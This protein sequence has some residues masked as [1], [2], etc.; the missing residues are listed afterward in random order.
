MHEKYMKIALEEANMALRA[1]DFPVGCV[2]TDSRGV[3][4]AGRRKNSVVNGNEL[5]HA[6]IVALRRL[7]RHHQHRVAPDLVVYSTMEPCLMC[8]SALIL[9]NI[10]TIVYAYEDVM[11]GGTK[12]PLDKLTPLY[13]SMK[14]NVIADVLR[15]ES[16]VLFKEFFKDPANFYWQDSLLARYTSDLPLTT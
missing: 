14:I 11:G 3:I 6:E 1:G 5:D 9:N 8:Y 4:C 10:R 12:L 15:S 13:S 7:Y 2:I 16:I